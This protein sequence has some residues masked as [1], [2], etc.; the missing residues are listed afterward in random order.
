MRGVRICVLG[1]VERMDL[2]DVKGVK[3]IGWG[4]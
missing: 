3:F 4:D 2:G 1:E